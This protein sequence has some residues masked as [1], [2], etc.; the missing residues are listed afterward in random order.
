MQ[1]SASEALVRPALR[2]YRAAI[3]KASRLLPGG[4]P[5]REDLDGLRRRV[6]RDHGVTPE[7]LARWYDRLG[8]KE[9]QRLSAECGL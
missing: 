3:L 4:Q 1:R 8:A 6:A 7:D 2:D 5:L 9:L